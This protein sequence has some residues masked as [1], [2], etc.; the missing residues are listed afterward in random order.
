ML[1]LVLHKLSSPVVIHR[2]LCSLTICLELGGQ[3]QKLEL[4]DLG[5]GR[6]ETLMLMPTFDFLKSKEGIRVLARAD[7]L[8]AGEKNRQGIRACQ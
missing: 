8:P 3:T 4:R 7:L 6:C 1:Q 2:R 5:S